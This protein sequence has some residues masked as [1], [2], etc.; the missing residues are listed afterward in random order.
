MRLATGAL[1]KADVPNDDDPASTSRAAVARCM[2]SHR[3]RVPRS[4]AVRGRRADLTR[5]REA[6]G[7][8]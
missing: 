2:P 4:Q 8:R 6:C 5:C 7:D 1:V 3:L